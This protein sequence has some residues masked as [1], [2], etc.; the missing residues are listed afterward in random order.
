MIED[1]SKAGEQITVSD[2][3]AQLTQFHNFEK[4]ISFYKLTPNEITR[5]IAENRNSAKRDHNREVEHRN[6]FKIGDRVKMK[7]KRDGLVAKDRVQKWSKGDYQIVG[8]DG[9]TYTI[10]PYKFDEEEYEI[11]YHKRKYI[12]NRTVVL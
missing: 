6:N 1:S 12:P 8:R 7:L 5:S 11:K 2:A 4:V 3:A 9:N 10:T